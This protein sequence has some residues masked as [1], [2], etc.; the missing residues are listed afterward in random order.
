MAGV[1]SRGSSRGR[2]GGFTLIE[3][4]VVVAIIAVLISILLPGLNAARNQ[5]KA[6][7]CGA[8]L[9]Q[10]GQ[11]MAGHLVES[12]WYPPAYVYPDSL[13]GGFELTPDSLTNRQSPSRE[14]GYLH[15]S[16]FLYSGGK[17]GD[18]AF[19]CPNFDKGGAPRT[20]PGPRDENWE[21]EQRDDPGAQQ[22]PGPG[23]GNRLEDRQA[24]RMSYTANAAVIPR[25]KF[26]S[27]IDGGGS[28]RLNRLVSDTEIRSTRRVI[29]AADF[30][31]SW[32][33]LSEQKHGGLVSKAHRS[34]NP[35]FNQSTS[36]REY[37]VDPQTGFNYRSPGDRNYGLQ[38]RQDDDAVD[39][40]GNGSTSP[41]NAIGR[42]HPGTDRLGG[43]A[44]FLYIDG[45]VSKKTVLKTLQDREWGEKFYS[46][47]GLIEIYDLFT[48]VE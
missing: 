32:K 7:K 33:A 10:V 31:N 35:F 29:L 27:N 41:L 39:L 47:D 20:N 37:D 19:Q 1:F 46:L 28:Q 34:V 21:N 12:R 13:Q 16:Y 6:A 25:N 36:Y 2:S 11:A 48:N 24:S 18:G 4:L 8:N 5:S 9:K 15:W 44:N 22:R 26:N 3:L 38:L 40:I 42:H 14:F 30:K 45:G 43:S 17:V 23:G